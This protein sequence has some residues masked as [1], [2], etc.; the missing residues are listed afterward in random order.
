MVKEV[1]NPKAVIP[2]AA[3]LHQACAHCAIFPTAASR[4]SLGRISVPVWPDTLSG[5]LPVVALVG[6][7]P[8]N[9]LIGRGPIPHRKSFPPQNMHPMVLSGIRPSFPSLSRSAGQITHVLLTRSPLEYPRKGLSVRLAC[10]KHA[11]SV[12]P[13]PGSNSPNKNPPPH[14]ARQNPNQKNLTTSKKTPKNWHQKNRPPTREVKR[15][16]KTTT[17]TKPPNTLLSSQTTP[18]RP[19]NNT[20]GSWPLTRSADVEGNPPKWSVPL[21]CRRALRPGRVAATRLSYVTE[22]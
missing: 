5:R 1:Y 8:T 3:S 14:R 17:K 19:R 6:H 4:R 21:G 20:R 12:R 10:V 22:N 18:R 7:H 2:H 16:Q 11:A 15:R 9:K 13:E